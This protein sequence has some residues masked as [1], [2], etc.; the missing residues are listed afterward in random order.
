LA[1]S[2]MGCFRD[3]RKTVGMMLLRSLVAHNR[4]IETY[5]EEMANLLLSPQPH[6]Q[7]LVA[8]SHSDKGWFADEAS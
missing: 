5:F 7:R 6:A 1:E 2:S 4:R 8:I 3:E